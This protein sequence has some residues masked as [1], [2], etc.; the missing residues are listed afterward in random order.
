MNNVMSCILKRVLIPVFT[1]TLFIPAFSQY[2]N[3]F[4]QDYCPLPDF[5]FFYDKQSEDFSLMVG[6]SIT[7]IIKA[8]ENK[9]YFISVKAEGKGNNVRFRL[10][11]NNPGKTLIFDNI[12][13]LQCDTFI[14]SNYVKRNL[15]LT[16][17]LQTTSTK[18]TGGKIFCMG[19]LIANRQVTEKPKPVEEPIALLTTPVVTETIEPVAETYTQPVIA[20]TVPTYQDT[21]TPI[22]ETSTS[23]STTTYTNNYK[24]VTSNTQTSYTITS[25]TQSAANNYST[26]VIP[27]V[28]F[29]V[30]LAAVVA[31]LTLEQKQR[32]YDGP[33]E[34]VEKIEGIWYK[35]Q[36][37]IGSDYEQAKRF[38][39]TCGVKGAFIVP[40]RDGKKI[41]IKSII[42]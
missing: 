26:R 22:A 17:T 6:D 42:Y 15:S 31:P 7:M 12:S 30:Q 14:F 35:Y 21:Y 4:H 24:P 8:A 41:D 28:V 39:L 3:D 23:S 37:V 32:I 5:S 20:E 40:Y 19:V 34:L 1:F 13:D 16:M 10:T 2:C 11:D 9:D 25:T 18:K 27:G 38:K 36:V 33:E 29:T